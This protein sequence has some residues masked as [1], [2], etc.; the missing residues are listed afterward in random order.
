MFKT[1]TSKATAALTTENTDV[2]SVIF[3]KN[4]KQKTKQNKNTTS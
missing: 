3:P 4:Q 2:G 1:D